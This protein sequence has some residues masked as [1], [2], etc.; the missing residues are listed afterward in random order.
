MN[1]DGL[2]A[3]ITGGGSGIGAECARVLAKEGAKIAVLD[4][5][6]EA[7]FDVAVLQSVPLNLLSLIRQF[8]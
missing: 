3:V 6:L 2:A 1:V 7:P 5:N 8:L 4:L